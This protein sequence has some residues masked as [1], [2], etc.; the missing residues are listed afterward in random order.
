MD[1]ANEFNRTFEHRIIVLGELKSVK[2]YNRLQ[3]YLSN[4]FEVVVNKPRTS[5]IMGQL[6]GSYYL[7][8]YFDNKTNTAVRIT[9]KCHSLLDILGIKTFGENQQSL[10]EE[11]QDKLQ[12]FCSAEQII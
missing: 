9:L 5:S 2:V 4:Q 6:A 7:A 3:S 11:L 8:V 12:E 1:T 10:L